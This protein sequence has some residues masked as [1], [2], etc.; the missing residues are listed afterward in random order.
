MGT[1]TGARPNHITSTTEATD[2]ADAGAGDTAGTT[3][4][5]RQRFGR[6]VAVILAVIVACAALV[7]YRT[8]DSKDWTPVWSDDFTG[9]RDTA[10]SSGNWLLSNGTSYPGGPAQWGTGERESYTSNP[11]NV[12]LDGAGN[13]RITATRDAAGTWNSARL[14]TQRTDFQAAPE[15]VLKVQARIRVPA[16]G[17][18]YWPAFWMLGTPFRGVY[19]N[20]PGIGEIDILENK[21]SEPSTV[22]GTLH[23]GVDPGGP[24]NETNGIGAHYASADRLSAGFHTY[25]VEWD[26]TQAVE[27]IRWYLDGHKYFTARSSDV[28]PSTWANA[29]HHGFFILLNLAVGGS[30]PG[31]TD[32]TTTPGGSMLVDYVRVS[33]R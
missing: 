9:A 24:C 23:C 3:R 27:Q 17:A 14:E 33:R 30:F 11:A 12:G 8:V 13:L 16:A 31:P 6:T 28:D 18:G 2:S 25:T 15:Q 1:P 5:N 22:Y 26:R 10:P 21:G 4:S 32:S 29:T 19:T 7:A 20:W